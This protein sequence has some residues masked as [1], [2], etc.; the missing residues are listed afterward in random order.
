MNDY[1]EPG[2]ELANTITIL[3]RLLV[4]F[5]EQAHEDG[6]PGQAGQMEAIAGQ[7]SRAV[8]EFNTAEDSK[9]F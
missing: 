6:K 8:D 5:A 7:L 2:Q 9:P 3:S 4:T 1:T